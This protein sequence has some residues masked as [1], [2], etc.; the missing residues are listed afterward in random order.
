[1]MMYICLIHNIYIYI[2]NKIKILCPIVPGQAW[3][4]VIQV[5]AHH[6]PTGTPGLA[7]GGCSVCACGVVLPPPGIPP[8][9]VPSS[10]EPSQG[11]AY[12]VN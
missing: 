7:G 4:W 6:D 3:V 1:M 5:V 10:I 8:G 12:A 2:K 11:A 9:A